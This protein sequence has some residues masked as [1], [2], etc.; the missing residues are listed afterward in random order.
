MKEGGRLAALLLQFQVRVKTEVGSIRIPASASA[1]FSGAGE[2]GTS[3]RAS[4][5]SQGA[6]LVRSRTLL[7]D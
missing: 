7:R 2:P 6:F 4:Q 5:P 3:D 1:G